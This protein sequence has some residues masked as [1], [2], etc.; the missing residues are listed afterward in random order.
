MPFTHS[1]HGLLDLPPGSGGG[2]GRIGGSCGVLLGFALLPREV[3][4]VGLLDELVGVGRPL[5]PAHLVRSPI[6]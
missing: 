2:G 3:P 6:V 4:L 5:P 1:L